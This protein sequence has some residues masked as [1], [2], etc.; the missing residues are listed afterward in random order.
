MVGRLTR[1]RTKPSARSWKKFGRPAVPPGVVL[2]RRNAA[3]K[4]RLVLP[5][6]YLTPKKIIVL[7]ALAQALQ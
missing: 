6:G 4:N 1:T 5:D 3:R 7:D 2:S